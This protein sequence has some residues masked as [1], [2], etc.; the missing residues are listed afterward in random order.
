M[1]L[2]VEKETL[3]GFLDFELCIE[4]DE[5]EGDGEDIVTRSA[6][7]VVSQ[8]V[9]RTVVALLILDRR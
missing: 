2:T 4:D 8:R 1:R 9:E 5:P 6:S 3:E 7:E